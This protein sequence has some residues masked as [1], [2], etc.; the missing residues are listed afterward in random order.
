MNTTNPVNKRPIVM[1]TLPER[2]PLPSTPPPTSPP[3][4]RATPS[5]N[6]SREASRVRQPSLRRVMRVAYLEALP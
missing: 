1:Y 5:K 2:I 3:L 4:L 6:H